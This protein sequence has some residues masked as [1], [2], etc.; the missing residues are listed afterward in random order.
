MVRRTVEFLL[1]YQGVPDFPAMVE[2]E[3]VLAAY[4]EFAATVGSG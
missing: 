4:G 2:L 1:C 3:D